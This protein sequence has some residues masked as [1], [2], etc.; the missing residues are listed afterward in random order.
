[1]ETTTNL[2]DDTLSGLK[3]LVKI[4]LDSSKGFE[5]AAEKVENAQIASLFRECG[6]E[7]S[8]NA[9]TLAEYVQINDQEAPESGSVAGTL[10]RWWL[11][12][13]GKVTS[14]NEY[15][16]LAEAERGEDHI[17]KMY[18]DVLNATAGSPLNGV[19]Q[20]QYAGVKA[21]HDKVRDMRDARKPS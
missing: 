19:L 4:N 7:R 9:S 14:E 1:M 8:N 13:R 5:A 12:I 17:K 6:S 18:E 15:Q 2:T 10:H 20:K 3:S 21:T 11:N 16:V